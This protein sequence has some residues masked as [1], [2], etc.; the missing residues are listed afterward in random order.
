MDK[1]RKCNKRYPARLEFLSFHP[2]IFIKFICESKKIYTDRVPLSD[3]IEPILK[4]ELKGR[5][6]VSLNYIKSIFYLD[7]DDKL[8]F[9]F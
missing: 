5:T 2:G 8:T 9:N 6:L 1:M 4:E 3:K 7:N